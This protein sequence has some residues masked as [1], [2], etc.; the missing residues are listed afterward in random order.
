[1]FIIKLLSQHVSGI[2]MPIIRKRRPCTTAYDPAPHKHSQHNQCRTTYTVVHG[3]VLL[4]M[5]IMMPETCWDRSLIINIGLVASCW[6]LSLHPIFLCFACHVLSKHDGLETKL[7]ALSGLVTDDV[8]WG[9]AVSAPKE[10]PQC[11]MYAYRRLTVEKKIPHRDS[12]HSQILNGAYQGIKKLSQPYTKSLLEA[13]KCNGYGE[14]DNYT[15]CIPQ[16]PFQTRRSSASRFKPTQLKFCAVN[17]TSL[18][19]ENIKISV[20]RTRST[21]YLEHTLHACKLD[22]R[23]PRKWFF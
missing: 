15:G 18:Y 4:M 2:I 11:P 16:P 20:C 17:P 12:K 5:G 1:M 8:K 9:S 14:N 6:I 7:H 23:I 21:L 13:D 10:W 3:L 19:L 22:L